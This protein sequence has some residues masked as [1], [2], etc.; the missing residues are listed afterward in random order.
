MLF[1]CFGAEEIGLLGSKF[2]NEFPLI[3]MSKIKLV[4]NLDIVGTGIEGIAL[5]NAL[6]QK[7]YAKT[8]KDNE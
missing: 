5:V 4:L 8:N 2:F 6:E 1:I 7:K 3:K